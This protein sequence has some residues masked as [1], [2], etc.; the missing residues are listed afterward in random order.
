MKRRP[1]IWNQLGYTINFS[2]Q[3]RSW[4][5]TSF[6]RKLKV[7]LNNKASLTKKCE[8]DQCKKV[9]EKSGKW[10]VFSEF[11]SKLAKKLPKPGFCLK[12]L[13]KKQPKNILDFPQ[14]SIQKL[15]HWAACFCLHFRRIAK[16]NKL[17]TPLMAGLAG[18][19]M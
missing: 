1:E 4:Q 15:S 8:I 18:C 7:P 12:G 5:D 13:L 3:N 17:K 2:F 19:L 6:S 9:W 16:I 14:T 10:L 11:P